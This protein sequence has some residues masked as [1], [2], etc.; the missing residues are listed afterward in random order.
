MKKAHHQVE[1]RMIGCLG[2][3]FGGQGGS[4]GHTDAE[5]N[6][7]TQTPATAE[8]PARLKLSHH[9]KDGMMHYSFGHFKNT[10]FTL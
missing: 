3:P 1:Q 10:L 5:V 9:S 7:G 2:E 6:D 8:L 4:V